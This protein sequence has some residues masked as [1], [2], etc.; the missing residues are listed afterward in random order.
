M[1]LLDTNIVIFLFKDRFQIADKIEKVGLENCYI[2]EIT[3]AELKFGAEKSDR[4]TYHHKIVN[5][6]I[7]EISVLPIHGFLDLYAKEKARL[8]KAGMIIH[9]FDILIGVTAIAHDLILI[10]N[11][12]T[13]LARLERIVTQDWTK[14]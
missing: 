7:Q 4:P 11:N 3:V 10:T 2:S 8:S 1:Y 12:T 6:F 5:E 9:D 13:H 14:E